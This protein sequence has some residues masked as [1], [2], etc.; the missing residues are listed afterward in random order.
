MTIWTCATCAIEHPD[1]PS[2]PE[3]CAICSDE[4]QY[5]P[6]G[7]QRWITRDE[8]EAQGMRIDVTQLETDLHG[9]TTR[10]RLGIGQRALLLRTTGG[11]LLFEPPGF[12]DA[13]G[14]ETVR[15]LGGVSA[16][17]SSHPHLTGSSIQWSHAFG[18]VPVYVSRQDRAWTRRPDDVITYWSDR[19]EILP[20]VTMVE[21]GG[22]F[23][24]SSLVHWQA[25]A[26]GQGALLTGDT[27]AIG[28]DRKSVNVM[29]SYVNNIP[30]PARAVRRIM[31]H[32]ASLPFER[33][34][35][36]F[37]ELHQ[38]AH[39]IVQRSLARY[40]AWLSDDVGDRAVLA[41]LDQ[42]QSSSRG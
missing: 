5:V 36:A 25:G 2:P 17:A 3:T 19:I 34:Y 12:I 18:R 10:P 6:V 1:T 41:A 9:V 20:G 15:V 22:H 13:Q 40:I 35:G 39:T 16:I 28:A 30:L 24:G 29:R 32:A 7:G 33:L 27:I 14:V 38:D 26:E 31:D 4:R 11:N 37:G 21:V 8:L 42:S 23:A